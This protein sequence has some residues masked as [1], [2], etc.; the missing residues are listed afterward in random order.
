MYPGFMERNKFGYTAPCCFLEKNKTKNDAAVYPSGMRGILG[1]NETPSLGGDADAAADAD[2]ENVPLT[3]DK[4]APLGRN[5]LGKT[6]RNW[7]RIPKRGMLNDA[8]EQDQL[9]TIFPRLKPVFLGVGI[10]YRES[11]L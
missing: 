11:L 1:F 10:N 3:K 6:L 7:K 2:D 5:V 8:S 9:K 4:I